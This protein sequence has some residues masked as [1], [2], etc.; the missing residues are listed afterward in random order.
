MKQ[1]SATF[2]YN[3]RLARAGELSTLL[4]VERFAGARFSANPA[5]ADITEDLTPHEELHQAQRAGRVWVAT[6]PSGRPIGFAFATIIDG[7]CHLEELSV[8]PDFGRRG[9]GAALV[10][11]VCA[12]AVSNN[13]AGVTLT[14]FSDVPWNAPFYERLGF[15]IIDTTLLTPG[16]ARAFADEKRR[17][18]PLHLR[19]VMRWHPTG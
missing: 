10:Q 15:E 17:G 11:T 9:V 1:P 18:L 7:Y 6:G 13:W 16:L 12:Y 3:I 5:L 4:D 14:T 2:P 19:C 8:L